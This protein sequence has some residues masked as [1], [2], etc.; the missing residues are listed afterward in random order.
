[1]LE[2]LLED[3]KCL[4]VCSHSGGKDSQAMY[5]AIR[6]LVPAERLVIVHATLGHIEWPGIVEH[7]M[8]TTYKSHEFF[9][10]AAAQKL[11]GIARRRRMWP[12]PKNRQC[13]SDL[14]RNPIKKQIVSLCNERGFNKVLNCIGLRAQES[15][16]RAQK[17]IFRQNTSK[18]YSNSRR[19]WFEWLPVHHLT[20]KEVFERIATAGQEPH[21]AYKAGMTRLSCS[22]CIM[23]SK[24][25]LRT[26]AKLRPELYQEYLQLEQEIGHALIMPSKKGRPLWLNE[27][28]ETNQ[29]VVF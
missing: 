9:V 1:M 28:V 3:P 25:D 12:S 8:A 6:D 23:S 2:Q 5:L 24:Q 15:T 10:V 22:F 29:L 7:I 27:I 19:K 14:K 11:F 18:S 4:V 16:S 17:S 20:T 21:W 26:A 13:T